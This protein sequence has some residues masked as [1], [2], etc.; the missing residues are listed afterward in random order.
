VSAPDWL[1]SAVRA[2]VPKGR[3]GVMLGGP[4]RFV[5]HTFEADPIHLGAAAGARI[6]VNQGTEVHFC[7]NPI[8]GELVQLLPASA[9]AYGLKNAPGGVETNRAGSVC[10]QVEVIAWAAHPFTA[11]MTPV[12]RAAIARLVRFARAH[13]IPDVWPAGPPP[14]Y[15]RGSSVRSAATWAQHA[16]HYGHS[17]VPENDHGDPGA[18]DTAALFASAPVARPISQELPMGYYMPTAPYKPGDGVLFVDGTGVYPVTAARW[19]V[20][21]TEGA[22]TRALPDAQWDALKAEVQPA[23]SSTQA[24]LVELGAKVDAL[25]ASL[26]PPGA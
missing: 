7:L 8:T 10:L 15:P 26:R 14:A 18:I 25:A 12:G 13:G 20:L 11:Y 22:T 3:G 21:R 19:A 16:G 24:R 5:W 2:S 23:E 17:Q 9:S 1:D 6:L 4:P